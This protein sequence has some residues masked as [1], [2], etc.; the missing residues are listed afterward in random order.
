VIAQAAGFA[1]LAAISPTALLVMVIFLGSANPRETALAYVAGAV[2]MTVLMAATVLLVLRGIGLNQPRESDP[3]YGLRLGL[4]VIALASAVMLRRGLGRGRLEAEAETAVEQQPQQGGLIGRL[5]AHPRPGLAFAAGVILFL[6]SATFVAA[7][8]VVATSNASP[9]LI[10][11]TLL[12]IVAISALIVWL[13]LLTYLVAPDAT[14]RVLRTLN[15][16]LRVHGRA[17]AVYALL[18]GGIA[19]IVNGSLGVAGVV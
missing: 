3:R 19:L 17:V 9:P 5:T 4:G 14:V 11:L 12:I 16:W 1:I 10:V 2:L 7:V 15:G 18:V 13:P 8:Q 6:P